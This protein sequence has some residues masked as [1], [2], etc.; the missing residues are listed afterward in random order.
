MK[1]KGATTTPISSSMTGLSVLAAAAAGG[2]GGGDPLV[3]IDQRGGHWREK[4]LRG[5]APKP[6][7]HNRLWSQRLL[8][9]EEELRQSLLLSS[10]L[11]PSPLPWRHAAA[12]MSAESENPKEEGGGGG[13][14]GTTTRV[15]STGRALYVQ[16]LLHEQRGVI[17]LH[18]LP[19]RGGGYY[20]EE[21]DNSS[22]SFWSIVGVSVPSDQRAAFDAGIVPSIECAKANER[23]LRL[24]SA[25]TA[26]TT[27]TTTT[28][29]RTMMRVKTAQNIWQTVGLRERVCPVNGTLAYEYDEALFQRRRAQMRRAVVGVGGQTMRCQ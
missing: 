8:E 6:W 15:R 21:E 18:R 26:T 11:K 2:G 13:G 25:T 20:Y 28:A 9:L 27:S 16:L 29:M 10:V 22:S 12:I 24:S 1:K 17:V 19:R 14:G 4:V 5:E 3:K 23:A 7:L